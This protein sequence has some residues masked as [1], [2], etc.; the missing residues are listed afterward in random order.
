MDDDTFAWC[1][2]Q[3]A[4]AD[5]SGGLDKGELKALARKLG[6]PLSAKELDDAMS[7]MDSDGGGCVELEEFQAWFT[8]LQTTEQTG[9]AKQLLDGAKEYMFN[10]MLGRDTGHKFQYGGGLADRLKAARER[11][12]AAISANVPGTREYRVPTVVGLKGWDP[13]SPRPDA[14]S[15]ASS[16]ERGSEYSAGI[17]NAAEELLRS[18]EP[19]VE[20]EPEPEPEPAPEPEPEPAPEPEPEAEGEISA[21][22]GDYAAQFQAKFFGA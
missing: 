11:L 2:F 4:D 16:S 3:E 17:A 6:Y 8:K 10:S 22:S 5:G 13:Q 20:P 21:E 7:E 18:R 1:L 14:W 12:S 19:Q 9:W 15:H